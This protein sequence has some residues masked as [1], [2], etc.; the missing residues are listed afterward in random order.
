MNR[1]RK[2]REES[3]VK[4]KKGK[5]KKRQRGNKHIRKTIYKSRKRNMKSV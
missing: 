2:K 4:G 1:E 5:E 3:K